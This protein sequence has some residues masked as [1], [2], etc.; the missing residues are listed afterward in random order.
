MA[1]PLREQRPHVLFGTVPIDWRE[2]S[3][4][5]SSVAVRDLRT[6]AVFLLK[7]PESLQVITSNYRAEDAA[8]QHPL[9]FFRLQQIVNLLRCDEIMHQSR[10]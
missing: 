1:V 3:G 7:I 5:C 4:G 8:G 10:S 9:Q 6:T 2:G